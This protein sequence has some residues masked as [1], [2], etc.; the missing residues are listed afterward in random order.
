MNNEITQ[1]A[2][3]LPSSQDLSNNDT[4]VYGGPCQLV[5][6]HVHTALSAHACPLKDGGT[7]GT[8]WFSIPAS[9]PAGTWIEAGGMVFSSTLHIDPNDSATG[10]VTI[11][12]T[13][14]HGGLAGSGA[15]L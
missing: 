11:V 15:G 10:Q 5:G 8:E 7:S 13:P 12:Y 4:E 3:H 6:V 14:N 9:S 2:T 1:A